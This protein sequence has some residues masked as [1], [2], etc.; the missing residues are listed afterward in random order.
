MLML[1]PDAEEPFKTGARVLLLPD[2]ILDILQQT[3]PSCPAGGGADRAE[4]EQELGA[5]GQQD[6]AQQPSVALQ[7]MLTGKTRACWYR[8]EALSSRRRARRCAA[9]QPRER[10]RR[11]VCP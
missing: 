2:P 5:A 3:E 8:S 9:V 6:G 11:R 4:E 10:L 1:T 7:G